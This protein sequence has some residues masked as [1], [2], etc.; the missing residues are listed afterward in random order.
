MPDLKIPDKVIQDYVEELYNFRPDSTEVEYARRVLQGALKSLF[1]AKKRQENPLSFYFSEL[2]PSETI[3]T[4]AEVSKKQRRLFDK[5]VIIEEAIESEDIF[6]VQLSTDDAYQS[7]KSC[8]VTATYFWRPAV[9]SVRG[10]KRKHDYVKRCQEALRLLTEDMIEYDPEQLQPL[11]L[12]AITREVPRKK[13]RRQ[14]L[15]LSFEGGKFVRQD[16]VQA[17]SPSA[18]I[19]IVADIGS[20]FH[21]QSRVLAVMTNHHWTIIGHGRAVVV[22]LFR[23]EDA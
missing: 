13:S 3:T 11:R 19:I 16:S 12:D 15:W 7:V 5:P 17:E 1:T 21:G 4:A 23:Q 18:P 2:V 6:A 9:F 10:A 8:A 22:Q 14:L 20:F